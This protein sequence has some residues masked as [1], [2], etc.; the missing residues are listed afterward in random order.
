MVSYF[1]VTD[2]QHV[3]LVDHKNAQL[4]LP[5]G[6]HVDDGEHPRTTV[7]RELFEEL[8][9]HAAHDIAAPLMITCTGTVGL[10]A[11]HTDVSL[12][13]VVHA[14]RE[15]PLVFDTGEFNSVRWFAFADLP[16]D[17]SDP[18]LRHFMDKYLAVQMAM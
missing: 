5:A 8:G 1:V 2:G 9:F 16:F 18:H 13:Y 7:Q 12:W 15:Q 3:L 6:G 17:R 10:T 11:G 4:W 14:R